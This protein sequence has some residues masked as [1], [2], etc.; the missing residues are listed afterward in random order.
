MSQTTDDF[1]WPVFRPLQ[2][3]GLSRLSVDLAAGLTLA[4]IAVPEQMATARLAG[5]APQVGL[6]AF[7]A[8]TVGFA[9]FGANRVLSA[10]ADSTIAPI[11]AGTLAGLAA[12]GSPLYAELA[13][14][15]AVM[16]GVMVIVAGAVRMGWVADL[17]SKPVLTGFMAGIALHIVLS[18]APSALGLPEERGDVYQRLGQF[19]GAVGHTNWTA[20]TIA[21]SVLAVT[22]GAERLSPRLPGALIALAGATIATAAL[23]LARHGLPVLGALPTGLPTPVW[24]RLHPESLLPLVGL[25]GVVGLVV[26]VQTAAVTRSFSAGD[27]DP[28]VDRDYIGVGAGN[29]LAGVF[30]AF[31]VNASPPRTAAV[32]EAGGRSQVGGL[33]AAAAVLLLAAFCGALLADTPTAALAGV[34]FFVA[35]HIFKARDFVHLARRAPAEFGL[36]AAT[37]VLLVLLPIQTGVAIGIFLSLVHGVFT[38]TRARLIPFEQVAGTTVWWPSTPD[39][40]GAATGEVLVV[41]FQAP[42]SFLNAFA[43]RRD[44]ERAIAARGRRP[45]LLVLEASS[46]VEVDFT[47][48]EVLSDSIRAARSKGVEFAIARL[49][50]VRAMSKLERFG[51]LDVLGPH[52]LF[53][54]VHEAIAALA[55]DAA[56]SGPDHGPN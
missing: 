56:S 10:G 8:A 52:H 9:I 16:V 45:R 2:G 42:L 55:P 34:L 18:Q 50:S 36:A 5:L 15:L 26:M 41:G 43:F 32:S 49:E 48:A 6:F 25:A 19:A 39:R 3:V 12:S 4:A 37:A 53:H 24:P 35:Q 14:V 20:A 11:F 22:M 51:V 27:A 33:A 21:F 30:G 28:D 54:S 40:L 31:P 47:A 38:I 1:R 44:V 7:V 46:I 23:G 17:L 29:F 13:A